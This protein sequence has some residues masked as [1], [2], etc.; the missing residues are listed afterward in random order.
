MIRQVL[1]YDSKENIASTSFP[2][3]FSESNI[4]HTNVIHTEIMFQ[5]VINRIFVA[6]IIFGIVMVQEFSNLIIHR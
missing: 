4:S 5:R 2:F 1:E 6:Q 3:D